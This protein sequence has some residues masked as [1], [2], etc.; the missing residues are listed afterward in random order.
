MQHFPRCETHGRGY[1]PSKKLSVG[2]DVKKRSRHEE[3]HNSLQAATSTKRRTDHEYT[4]NIQAI[5]TMN[6]LHPTTTFYASSSS[7]QNTKEEE[8]EEFSWVFI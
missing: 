8:E 6:L 3:Q 7:M 2:H 1:L 5:S 4:M